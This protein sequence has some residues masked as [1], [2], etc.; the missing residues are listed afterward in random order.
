MTAAQRF[1][2]RLTIVTGHY[3]TGKTEFSVN[4]AL[5]LAAEG[6]RTALADLDI[7]NPY[8]RSRERRELLEGAGVRLIAASQALAD[9]DVPALPA[10][11]HAVLEDRSVRG[12]LDVGGDPSGA[13]VLARYR[14]RILKEDYQLLCIVNA[15]RPEVRT[16]ERSAEYLRAI[17]AVAGLRCTGLVNNTHLCGET[18]PEDIREGA[19]LAEEVSQITGIPVVCHT[20]ERR[21]QDRLRDL[22]LF[23]MEIRMKKPWE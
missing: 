2:H 22:P 20:A 12:V 14:P 17:E 5:A 3:G 11:L 23:P 16:A 10:E 6:A 4:L 9:A 15:A 1:P 19:A 18:A 8:F 13:R 7:V 21:F